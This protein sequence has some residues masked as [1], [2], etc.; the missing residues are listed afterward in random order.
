MIYLLNYFLIASY[1]TF[2]EFYIFF[3]LHVKNFRIFFII[4][5][6]NYLKFGSLTLP[7]QKWGGGLQEFF[8]LISDFLFIPGPWG[9]FKG[10]S[11][12]WSLKF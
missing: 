9:C 6:K 1:L 11:Y 5:F 10:S 8:R 2:A 3:L 4:L 7:D 12:F